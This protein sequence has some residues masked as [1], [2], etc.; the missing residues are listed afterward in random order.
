MVEELVE[1]R[2]SDM[3]KRMQEEKE[4]LEMRLK[5]GEEK[6][7]KEKKEQEAMIKAMEKR[8][9]AKDEEIETRL[10]AKNKEMVKRLGA[11]DKEMETRL[12]NLEDRMNQEKDEPGKNQRE[13]EASSKL[14]TE[15][16]EVEM[17]KP[18]VRDLPIVIISAWQPETIKSP[19]T[20]TFASFL[21]NYNNGERPGD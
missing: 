19:Q 15:V 11:K 14:R 2:L 4:E 16:E 10:E 6:Q 12:K 21:A 9:E 5:Y 8:L 17:T 20:V 18:S 3:K 1:F 7:R 13:W